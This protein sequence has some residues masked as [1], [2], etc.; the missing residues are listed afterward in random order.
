MLKPSRNLLW[1]KIG[2]IE[3]ASVFDVAWNMTLKYN[4]GHQGVDQ[5]ISRRQEDGISSSLEFSLTPL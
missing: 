1:E 4:S 3:F 2:L 5:V